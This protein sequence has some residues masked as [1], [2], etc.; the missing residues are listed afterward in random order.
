[1]SLLLG[2]MNKVLSRMFVFLLVQS[3]NPL[4]S[5]VSVVGSENEVE[6]GFLPWVGERLLFS[7]TSLGFKTVIV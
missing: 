7:C 5:S 3:G 1:M 4:P 2:Y 6:P